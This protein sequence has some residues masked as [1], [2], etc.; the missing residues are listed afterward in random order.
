MMIHQNRKNTQRFNSLRTS[1][2]KK[3]ISVTNE[4]KSII[5][6][7]CQVSSIPNDNTF[8]WEWA[9]CESISR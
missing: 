9:K 8:I 3:I 1:I 6:V 2:T 7:K 5:S 4:K